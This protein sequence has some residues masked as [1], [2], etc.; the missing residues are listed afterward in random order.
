MKLGCV[1]TFWAPYLSPAML[2]AAQVLLAAGCHAVP[3]ASF[4]GSP[5]A[6]PSSAASFESLQ[7]ESVTAPGS[8]STED[9]DE[10]AREAGFEVKGYTFSEPFHLIVSYDWLILQGPAKPVFEGDPLVLHCRAWQD[11]PLSQVTFYRDGLALGPPGPNK[12]FSIAVVQE[13]DS[14][15]YH[16]S[17]IF[18][19]PG[20]GSP[21]KA[22]AVTITV[23]EL[24]PAPVLK[25]T[26]SAEPHEGGP[27]TLSCQTKLPLQRSATRLLFSFYKDGRTVRSKD[28]S[29][30]FQVP[31]ASE[32]H[33][34]SYWCEAAT[35]DN[36][37]WKQSPQLEIRVQG[38]SKSAAS[39]TLNPAPQKPAA[40]ETTPTEPPG[41]LPPLPT[42]PSQD[43]CFSFRLEGP[44][45]HLH[46]QM[47]ILLKHME[48]VR[49][50]LGYMVME[51]RDLSSRFKPE[52]TKAASKS[53]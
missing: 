38:P 35:E 52:T 26:P 37:V 30:E 9:T 21:E 14:G 31:T 33:S 18:R 6:V 19:S 27:V 17:G 36:Q 49:V 3:A 34:G 42:P 23:Q 15:L 16:C 22:S 48:D 10:G 11:W 24:F 47:G 29:S 32:E 39:P 20:P 51:L 44:D 5:W 2:W 1:L 53:K 28:L 40:P 4:P 8:V 50:L 12:E 46:H 13:A 45:P 25:A 7:C 41:P 43:P